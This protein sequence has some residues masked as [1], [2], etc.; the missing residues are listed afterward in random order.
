MKQRFRLFSESGD[1]YEVIEITGTDEWKIQDKLD[2]LMDNDLSHWDGV[3]DYN[4]PL[5]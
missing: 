5:Q 1:D 4:G 3:E 2:F